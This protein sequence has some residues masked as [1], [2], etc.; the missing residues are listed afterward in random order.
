MLNRCPELK[1]HFFRQL[2]GSKIVSLAVQEAKEDRLEVPERAR[3]ALFGRT[4]MFASSPLLHVYTPLSR[5]ADWPHT[6]LG[7]RIDPWTKIPPYQ[8][9]TT[10]MELAA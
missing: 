9:E 6:R 5:T 2:E 4:N 3:V 1:S 7:S 10:L 8:T